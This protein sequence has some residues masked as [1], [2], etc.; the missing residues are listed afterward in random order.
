MSLRTFHYPEHVFNSSFDVP[1]GLLAIL[2]ET[3]ARDEGWECHLFTSL[4]NEIWTLITLVDGEAFQ[5]RNDELFRGTWVHD[6]LSMR[7]DEGEYSG[8]Y[9]L[10]GRKIPEDEFDDEE[11]W[12]EEYF[13]VFGVRREPSPEPEY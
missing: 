11:Q 9:S 7:Y 8:L 5:W 13:P 10:E 12:E 3:I 2:E 4:G 6:R 1:I